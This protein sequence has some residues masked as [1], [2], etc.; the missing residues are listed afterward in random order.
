MGHGQHPRCSLLLAVTVGCDRWLAGWP[1]RAWPGRAV[2]CC[3]ESGC[4]V[5]GKKTAAYF[6]DL[7][8]PSSSCPLLLALLLAACA[9]PPRFF[10]PNAGL[11]LS[12]DAPLSPPRALLPRHTP[13]PAPRPR[14]PLVPPRATVA[15]VAPRPFARRS[16]V[17]GRGGGDG[18]GTRRIDGRSGAQYA[19]PAQAES[20]SNAPGGR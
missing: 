5:G 14:P 20:C 15:I 7:L 17:L 18:K 2:C 6:S 16:C 10:A 9:P 13:P 1:G 8:S 4:A 3:V 11:S 19:G 12:L